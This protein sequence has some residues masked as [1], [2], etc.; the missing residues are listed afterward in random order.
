MHGWMDEDCDCNK[1]LFSALYNL[2]KAQTAAYKPSLHNYSTNKTIKMIDLIL[3]LNSF[4]GIGHR[5]SSGS[6]V[7]LGD[8]SMSGYFEPF[9]KALPPAPS[10]QHQDQS[11]RR[12][13]SRDSI[14]CSEADLELVLGAIGHKRQQQQ[15]QQ[16]ACMLHNKAQQQQQL[17]QQQKQL[18]SILKKESSFSKTASITTNP[19]ANAANVIVISDRESSASCSP[20]PLSDPVTIVQVC[21]NNISKGGKA[22]PPKVHPKPGKNSHK[23]IVTSSATSNSKNV[24]VLNV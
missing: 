11:G 5:D 20:P 14:A 21:S 3:I 15:Q 7:T 16:L 12:E 10:N 13:K 24:Y 22:P 8:D 19:C 9:G 18:K 4:S 2:K 1:N 17:S 6:E 23:N